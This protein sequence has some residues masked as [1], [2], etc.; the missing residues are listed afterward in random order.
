MFR[1]RDRLSKAKFWTKWYLV[2]YLAY[3]NQ[4]KTF[5]NYIKTHK[6]RKLSLG[7]WPY[8][9]EGWLNTD[10]YGNE[11]GAVPLNLLKDF[12]LKSG[13]FNYV[14][15]EHVLEH[16]SLEEGRHILK[17]SF[18]V[19]KKGG[20]IRIATPDLK[21]LIDMYK[22]DKTPTQKK[23]L[24]WS[25]SFL[26]QSFHNDTLL[27]NTIVRA[28]GHQFIYDFKTLKIILNQLGFVDVKQYKN[29]I[30]DDENLKG[31]ESHWK[32]IGKNGK[33][34]N[35]LETVVVEAVKP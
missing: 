6:I 14:F 4:Q 11:E 32:S 35:D 23:Y 7:C 33:E 34:L 5:E 31:L 1:L 26:N 13:T 8:L 21:F 15:S 20:K 9:M 24:K 17:E 3:F 27:I 19:L 22:Q 28:W 10:L 18:R 12:P 2:N 16:F 30:S 25:E 29:G